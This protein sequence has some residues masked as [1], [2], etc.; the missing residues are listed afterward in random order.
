[1]EMTDKDAQTRMETLFVSYKTLFS[2]N[3]LACLV[4]DNEKVAVYHVLSAVC[5]E[6]PLA[7]LESDL[8]LSHYHLRKDFKEFMAHAVR[9]SEAFQLVDNGGKSHVSSERK[10]HRY[11]GR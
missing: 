7:R 10:N 3:G 2:R 9:L 5:P 8:E 4:D 1:M 6:S 11:G